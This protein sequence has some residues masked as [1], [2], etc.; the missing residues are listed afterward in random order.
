MAPWYCSISR[1]VRGSA[2]SLPTLLSLSVALLLGWFA[3]PV[4]DAYAEA[5]KAAAGK[6]AAEA[7]APAAGE[8]PE[9]RRGRFLRIVPPITDKLDNRVRLMIDATIKEAQ[10]KANGRFSSSKSI[11]AGPRLARPSIWPDSFPAP[12]ST[13]P[14]PCLSARDHF[15]AQRAGGDGLRRNHHEPRGRDRRGG[16]IRKGHR[17]LGP[18]RLR[19]DR[20]SAQDHP[21]P[22][23]RLG[24]LDPA[25]EVVLVE[26]DVSREF[27]L[28]VA[29]G[30]AAQAKIVPEARRS[31]S[32]PASRASSPGDAG[33][34]LGFVSYLAAD[35]A[36]VAKIWELPREAVED[37]PSLDGHWRPV[38][39]V[40]QRP[41]H[42]ASSPSK[43]RRML[44]N[45][46]QRSRRELH[47]A[48]G[49]TAPAARPT[50]SIN[51]ANFLAS[52]D[53]AK[54]RTVAYIP[55]EARG[56]AAFIALACDHIVM[57]PAAMLGGS[58]AAPLEARRY[59]G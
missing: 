17:A 52:L 39:I 29:L 25:V 21:E 46:I 34:E 55:S 11:P 58:G 53:P 8:T 18:Q 42:A 50:D 12:R 9:R 2:R 24:M 22:T 54:R 43:C 59:A 45:Q 5:E 31:S 57:H 1:R 14:R 44:Q 51:L 30:R 6:V 41:D 49:S 47:S 33:W 7:K 23:W 20:Q 35:R 40:Y 10:D 48:C 15:R 4:R 26:T 28:A 38:R 19:R 27:V 13:A 3:S 32:R 36:E 56:D 16:R 37:D